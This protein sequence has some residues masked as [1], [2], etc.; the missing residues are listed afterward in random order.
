[1]KDGFSHLTVAAFRAEHGI[2]NE[3]EPFWLEFEALRILVLRGN[4][5]QN[6][7]WMDGTGG[8]LNREEL[9]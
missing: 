3:L 6:Q 5:G 7:R 4:Q 1:M 2:V 9:A 8:G